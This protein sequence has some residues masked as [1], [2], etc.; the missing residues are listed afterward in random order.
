MRG[1]LVGLSLTSKERWH[2]GDL[3]AD[4]LETDLWSRAAAGLISGGEEVSLRA[5]IRWWCSISRGR[6]GGTIQS[7]GRGSG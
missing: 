5:A 4:L 2:K 3:K 1:R 7:R 6:R